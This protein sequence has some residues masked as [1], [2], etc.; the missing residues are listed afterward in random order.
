M[1]RLFLRL[2]CFRLQFSIRDKRQI[3]N[4]QLQT[5]K[6]KTCL[7]SHRSP[8][9]VFLLSSR[10]CCR[11]GLA[12][13]KEK[14]GAT[15]VCVWYVINS[16]IISNTKQ[17]PFFGEREREGKSKEGLL[18]CKRWQKEK[19]KEEKKKGIFFFFVCIQERDDTVC[20]V[21]QTIVTNERYSTPLDI[22]V[23]GLETLLLSLCVRVPVSF[24]PDGQHPGKPQRRNAYT[25]WERERGKWLK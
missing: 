12:G 9:L 24:V 22:H 15:T 14:S 20:M 1:K 8:C 4:I 2:K 6:E 23:I 3:N 10:Y 7:T 19:T 18:V 5:I 16:S 25:K 21:D 17:W 11:F 13:N